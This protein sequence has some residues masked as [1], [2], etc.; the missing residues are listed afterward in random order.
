MVVGCELML[1]FGILRKLR[2]LLNVEREIEGRTWAGNSTSVVGRIAKDS[3]SEGDAWVDVSCLVVA[4]GW[5][6][7]GRFLKRGKCTM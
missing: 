1:F 6:I 7:H 2:Q 3:T 5:L 4:V